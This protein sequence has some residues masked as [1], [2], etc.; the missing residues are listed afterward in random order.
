[1]SYKFSSRTPMAEMNMTPFID[2]VLVLLVIFMVA[3]P[4]MQ[5]GVDVN[6]PSTH[7]NTVSSEDKPIYVSINATGDVFVNETQVDANNLITSLSENKESKIFIRADST[8]PYGRI[9]ETMGI[10]QKAGFSKVSLVGVPF[11]E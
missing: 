5:V 7:G 11:K 8:L 4:M 6:L 10:L 1:M 2:V 3:A 9:M